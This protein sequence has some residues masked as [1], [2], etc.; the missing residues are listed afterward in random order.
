MRKTVDSLQLAVL[1]PGI[2]M[3]AVAS[4]LVGEVQYDLFQLALVIILER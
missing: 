4:H 2:K 3:I 1:L